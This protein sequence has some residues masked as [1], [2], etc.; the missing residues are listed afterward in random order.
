MEALSCYRKQADNNIYISV[1]VPLLLCFEGTR[2]M[3]T[4][5]TEVDVGAQYKE[6]HT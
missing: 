1:E 3:E 6:L 4:A 5:A 2:G